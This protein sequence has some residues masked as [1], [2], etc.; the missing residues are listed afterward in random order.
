MIGPSRATRGIDT[1]QIIGPAKIEE[2]IVAP[3]LR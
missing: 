3:E 1:A 2:I